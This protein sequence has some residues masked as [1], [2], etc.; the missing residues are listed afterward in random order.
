MR[1]SNNAG[2]NA[3]LDVLKRIIN[4]KSR[5]IEEQ[6]GASGQGAAK[7]KRKSSAPVDANREA[8]TSSPR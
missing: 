1:K 5:L 7:P 2:E 3:Q 8:C 6:R 4:A